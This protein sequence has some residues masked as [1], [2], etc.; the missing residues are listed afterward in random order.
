MVNG[1]STV[2]EHS[3]TYPEIEG[4]NPA[5]PRHSEKYVGLHQMKILIRIVDNV[6]SCNTHNINM[7]LTSP[8]PYM[9]KDV[10]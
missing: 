1:F 2:V 5:A 6:I 4:S 7:Y 9:P 8:V 10:P 3:T